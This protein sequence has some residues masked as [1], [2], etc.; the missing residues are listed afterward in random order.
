MA[1]SLTDPY[2]LS[3]ILPLLAAIILFFVGLI[4][5]LKKKPFKSW[6]L[7]S[8]LVMVFQQALIYF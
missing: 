6:F 7:A 4:Q 8:F 3:L 2:V 5:Y 1:R